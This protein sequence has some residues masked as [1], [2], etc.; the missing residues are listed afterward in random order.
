MSSASR[1]I[2]YSR[3]QARRR[4][5]I[6][7][8]RLRSW[9]K[10]GLIKPCESYSFTDLV[11]LQTL[12]RL[13]EQ[14][15]SA[16]VI[17][18]T[19]NSLARKLQTVEDPLRECR[20]ICEGGRIAVEVG[21]RRMDPATGQ[22]L[23]DFEGGDFQKMLVFPEHSAEDVLKAAEAARRMESAL[24]FEKAV[25]LEQAGAP[26]QEVVSAYERAVELDPTSAGALVNLGTFYFNRKDFENAE[27]YYR[28]ALE[29]EP[30]YALAHFNLGNLFDERGEYGKALLHYTMALRLDPDYADAHYN[31]AL[32]YQASGQLL[33]AVRHWKAYLRLDPSSSWARTARQELE[34]LRRLAVI[35]GARSQPVPTSR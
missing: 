24:W 30:S 20:L 10:Q 2:S 27:Q 6:S 16:A 14:G 26:E 5:G 17:K 18:R 8:R 34:K 11:A 28:R 35:P 4:L 13:A 29:V 21:G 1:Q 12:K 22:L 31:L 7:E 15:A 3:T 32:L 19:V 23:L 25:K 33:R 9:E